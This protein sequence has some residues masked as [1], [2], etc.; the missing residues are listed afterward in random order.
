L[1]AACA[2]LEIPEPEE[3][4]GGSLDGDDDYA[5]VHTVGNYRVS[6][7][8]SLA[9]LWASVDWSKFNTPRDLAARI[10]VLNDTSIVPATCG[11]VVAQANTRVS[12]DGFGLVYPGAHVWFPTCHESNATGMHEYDVAMY[13]C[14]GLP[15]SFPKRWFRAS[16]GKPSATVSVGAPGCGFP[17]LAT[18][19]S[20]AYLPVIMDSVHHVQFVH[21]KGYA[22]NVNVCGPCPDAPHRPSVLLPAL[23]GISIATTAP[24]FRCVPERVARAVCQDGVLIRNVPDRVTCSRCQKPGIA[25]CLQVA[26]VQLCMPC[27]GSL[28]ATPDRK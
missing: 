23:V 19:G 11:F 6:V 17:A 12:N 25:S 3:K 16:I 27:V 5:A 15:F 2:S 10:A 21:A 18:D 8:P 22:P 28:C 14:N 20:G 24:S 1:T 7:V 13:S 4:D 9:A 26:E